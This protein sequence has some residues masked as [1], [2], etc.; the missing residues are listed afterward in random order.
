MKKLLSII[1]LSFFLLSNV[2]AKEGVTNFTIGKEKSKTN[3]KNIYYKNLAWRGHGTIFHINIINESNKTVDAIKIT[4]FDRD[5]DKIDICKVEHESFSLHKKLKI[6]PKTG[7]N[8]ESARCK[9]NSFTKSV[10]I[11]VETE[12]WY[13][14]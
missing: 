11:Q 2:F 9:L 6:L 14:F 10:G 13:E 3:I 8:I 1:T 7:K 4:Y 12:K 5:G